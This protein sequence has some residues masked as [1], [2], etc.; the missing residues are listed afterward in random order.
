MSRF[1]DDIFPQEALRLSDAFHL[2]SLWK[3]AADQ[4]FVKVPQ[5]GLCQFLCF[6]EFS[7]GPFEQFSEAANL[8]QS[9]YLDFLDLQVLIKGKRSQS[10][11]MPAPQPGL[12][13]GLKQRHRGTGKNNPPV[14]VE[15]NLML[16]PCAPIANKLRFIQEQILVP[17]DPRFALT[18][19]LQYGI[20]TGKL[21][22]GMIE[23]GIQDVRRGHSVGQQS[24]DGLH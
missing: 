21:Q 3:P 11:G 1:V 9:G 22:K 16:N 18:P 6:M 10:N 17:A 4:I 20:A 19:S 13:V 12:L 14:R 7:R 24:G 2:G 23:C 5:V 15:I 8:L